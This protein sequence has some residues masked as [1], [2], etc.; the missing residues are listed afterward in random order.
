MAIR[1]QMFF[2]WDENKMRKITTPSISEFAYKTINDLVP[3]KT[4]LLLFQ[5]NFVLKKAMGKQILK[6]TLLSIILNTSL[7]RAK[8]T[9]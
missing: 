7:H 6:T 1:E 4:I 3:N 5:D 2:N 8:A 9:N